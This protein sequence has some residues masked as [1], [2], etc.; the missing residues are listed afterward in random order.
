[1]RILGVNGIHNWSWSKNSFTDKLLDALSHRHETVDVQ[2]PRMWALLAYFD[3]AIRRRA[4]AIVK[5]NKSAKDILIAHSFGCLA[6]IYAMELGAKF[7]KVFFF[8]AAAE[9]DMFIPNS[10]TRLF[11]IHSK[12]DS[13][14]S[15]GSLLPFHKF[16]TLGRDGYTGKNPKVVNIEANGHGH[17]DYVNSKNLCEWVRFIESEVAR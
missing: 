12:D 3:I 1:M 7:D 17:N 15:L 11:N 10:F 13:T 14:L 6:S 4:E 9:R 2:Y 8:G 5:A 16:G